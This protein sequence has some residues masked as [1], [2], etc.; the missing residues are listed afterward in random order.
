MLTIRQTSLPP[1][2]IQ[3][4][5]DRG[6]SLG[7]FRAIHVLDAYG[8]ILSDTRKHLAPNCGVAIQS[9]ARSSHDFDAVGTEPGANKLEGGFITLK[10]WWHNKSAW[11][12]HFARSHNGDSCV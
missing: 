6:Q 7:W 12:S 1:F 10:F 11:I 8:D 5:F 4:R 2:R 3:R 9:R